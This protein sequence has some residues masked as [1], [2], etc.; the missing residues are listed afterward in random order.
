MQI[1]YSI[2]S[3]LTYFAGF[4]AFILAIQQIMAKNRNMANIVRFFHML[5][6]SYALF[7][8]GIIANYIP[9]EHPIAG[10][11][12]LTSVLLI[13]PTYLFSI[14]TLLGSRKTL[15]KKD[16]LH[17]LPAIIMLL[18][19][20]VFQLQGTEFKSDAINKFLIYPF[21]TAIAPICL[22]VL[23]HIETYFIMIIRELIPFWN[24]AE[25]KAEVK[26]VTMRVVSSMVV[27]ALFIGGL[28]LTNQFVMLFSGTVSLINLIGVAVTQGNYP[29]F[30]FALRKEYRKKRY[31]RSVIAGLNT[32]AIQNRL[33]ELMNDEK[34]YKDADLNLQT[35]AS[36]LS[37]T[38]H[39]LSRLLNEQLKVSFRNYVNAY[40]VDE[41]KR[42]L[43]TNRKMSISMVCY[44][45]GFG[46][47]ST[48]HGAVKE[49]TGMSPQELRESEI[50]KKK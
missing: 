32:D 30:F 40:R 34:I 24:K 44:E 14:C 25:I 33:D 36:H 2:L 23:L 50:P 7:E 21:H 15:Q 1:V 27:A 19:E 11:F 13:G 49:V 29:E 43:V 26:I 12:Y 48:F 42:L 46:S 8:Q 31:E 39:Q 22:I 9:L 37:I 5:V 28:L 17:F 6:I 47:Y 18:T 4:L 45:A 38:P 20:T 3:Y 16:I 35:L 10:F 41:A